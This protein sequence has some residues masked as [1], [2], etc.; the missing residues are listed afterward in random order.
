M[1]ITF[2]SRDTLNNVFVALP[3][4]NRQRYETLN[5]NAFKVR[6]LYGK[7]QHGDRTF[8]LSCMRW[9]NVYRD[10]LF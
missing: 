4:H 8:E 7:S 1:L 3:T 6:G 10:I 2:S 9:L 5:S